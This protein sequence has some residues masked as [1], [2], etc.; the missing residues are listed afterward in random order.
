MVSAKTS[1][2]NNSKRTKNKQRRRVNQEHPIAY[3]SP[4]FLD[5]QVLLLDDA[6]GLGMRLITADAS[7]RQLVFA[8][9]VNVDE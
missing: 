4:R 5:A 9:G 2:R 6:R 8:P 3:K 7:I 1:S